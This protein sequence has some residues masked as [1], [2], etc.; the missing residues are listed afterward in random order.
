M[1][2]SANDEDVS[3]KKLTK[4][5]SKQGKDE[6]I[7]GKTKFFMR[8]RGN[9]LKKHKT[10]K[11]HF[12]ISTISYLGTLEQNSIPKKKKKKKGPKGPPSLK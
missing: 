6:K 10:S 11:T 3:T 7:I 9:K 2:Y 12:I 1:D 8:T 5:Y 4:I